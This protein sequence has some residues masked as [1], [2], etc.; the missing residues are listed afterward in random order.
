MVDSI[1]YP[2]DHLLIIDNGRELP[3]LQLPELVKEITVLPMPHNLGVAA[4]WN[5]GI[6]SFP[7]ADRWVFTSADTQ[8]LPGALETLAQADIDKVT[9]AK[10]F[11]YWQTFALGREA[12]AKI[13]LFDENLYPIYYEDTD[14]TLRA[15]RLGVEAVY[16]PIRVLHN[17]S[18]TIASDARLAVQNMSTFEKN[19]QY[20]ET[21]KQSGD[22]T[23]GN[24]SLEIWRANS[25]TL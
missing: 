9:L 4:S 20:L 5:L 8:Y 15:S 23:A 17:N 6:K 19:G 22:L 18:S 1:D 11:P 7:L 14:Y 21:K 25:W 10:D 12:V 24:W 16:A 3:E 2:V 13:G